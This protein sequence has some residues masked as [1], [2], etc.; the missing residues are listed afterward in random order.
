MAAERLSRLQRRILPYVY[1]AEVRSRGMVTASHLELVRAVGGNKG[2]VSIS[3]RNLEAK[4]LVAIARTRGGHAEA[5][6][7]TREGKKRAALLT[8]SFD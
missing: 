7:L 6:A 5:V 1:A 4:G 3:V 2:N 8:G